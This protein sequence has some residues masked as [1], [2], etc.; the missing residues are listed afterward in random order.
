[1]TWSPPPPQVQSDPCSPNPC[2]NKAQCHNKKG[3]FYCSCPDDYEGKTCSELK[4]HCKTNHC[5]GAQRLLRVQNPPQPLTVCSPADRFVFAVWPSVIDSCTVAVATNDT[6]R[7]VWH[8]SSNVCGPH[9][10]CMSLPAGNFSC[11]CDPGFTGTYCHESESASDSQLL[12][13][14][15]HHHQHSHAFQ[16]HNYTNHQSQKARRKI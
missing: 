9:G 4:D 13:D 16:T 10:R 1:M 8:I 15:S 7:R 3:D 5:Q 2:N 11:S 14:A 6:Q 12:A